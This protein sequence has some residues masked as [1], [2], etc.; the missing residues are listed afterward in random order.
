MSSESACGKEETGQTSTPDIQRSLVFRWDR[1][2]SATIQLKTRA[3]LCRLSG[4]MNGAFSA[5]LSVRI[6]C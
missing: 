5:N 2:R 3:M 6:E 4:L 1:D